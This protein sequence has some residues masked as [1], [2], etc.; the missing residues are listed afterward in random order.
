MK[1]HP[2]FW[3]NVLLG[4]ACATAYALALRWEG[5]DEG[6]LRAA[7]LGTWWAG[8]S[9]GLAI[10]AGSTLGPR[11]A[12]PWKRCVRVHLM[13]VLTSALGA[14]LAWLLPKPW[15]AVDRVVE[16]EMTRRGLSLGSGI[17]AAV[18]TGI[19]IVQVYLARR[20]ASQRNC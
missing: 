1:R 11:P 12:L 14:L 17:G 4:V 18:G 3:F 10:A 9:V 8:L 2:L 16:E 5:V 20:R 15:Q 6:A 7:F 19:Q 13:V